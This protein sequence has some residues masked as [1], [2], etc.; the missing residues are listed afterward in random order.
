MNFACTI[1]LLG[2]ELK[3]SKTFIKEAQ[4]M[5]WSLKLNLGLSDSKTELLT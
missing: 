5:D 3:N 4:V 2:K 1:S